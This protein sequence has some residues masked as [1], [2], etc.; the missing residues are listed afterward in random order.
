MGQKPTRPT[1]R[2]RPPAPTCTLRPVPTCDRPPAPPLPRAVA[3]GAIALGSKAA[4]VLK[5]AGGASGASK[6]LGA[7]A[8]AGV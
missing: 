1:V 3:V 2:P 5:T 7:L 6:A 8:A 4:V